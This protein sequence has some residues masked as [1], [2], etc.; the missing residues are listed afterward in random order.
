[1][2]FV[3]PGIRWALGVWCVL[4]GVLVAGSVAQ[5]ARP[6]VT[7]ALLAFGVA[8]ALV[9][10]LLTRFRPGAR[11]SSQVLYDKADDTK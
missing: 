2:V 6:V 9:L 7:W 1:M 5:G 8:P 10:A 11:S 4:A 3:T